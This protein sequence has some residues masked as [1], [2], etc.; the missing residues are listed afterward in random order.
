MC[1]NYFYS[2]GSFCI[3]LSLIVSWSR[4]PTFLITVIVAHSRL[5]RLIV[6]EKYSTAHG[7][8]LLLCHDVKINFSKKSAL[9]LLSSQL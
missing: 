5:L 8:L 3:E 9:S 2:P 6:L 4:R 7:L 1:V